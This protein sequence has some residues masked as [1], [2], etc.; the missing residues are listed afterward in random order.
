[1]SFI[2]GYLLGLSESRGGSSGNAL[3]VIDA[4]PTLAEVDIGDGWSVKVKIT[5]KLFC[6]SD[7]NFKITDSGVIY[8]NHDYRT[9]TWIFCACKNGIEFAFEP[10][11]FINFS[12][13]L[14]ID[15]SDGEWDITGKYEITNVW[16]DNGRFAGFYESAGYYPRA[17]FNVGWESKY[18]WR[19]SPDEEFQ[20][21]TSTNYNQSISVIISPKGGITFWKNGNAGSEENVNILFEYLTACWNRSQQKPN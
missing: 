12:D 5:N 17:V 9:Y 16:L 20:V 13:S 10:D 2:A 4:L 15:N 11:Y 6:N 19:S 3:D 7:L 18:Y 1:M 21:S 14:Y 8:P